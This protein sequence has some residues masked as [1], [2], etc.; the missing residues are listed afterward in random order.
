[1]SAKSRMLEVLTS[2]AA[3]NTFSVAQG[4]RRFGVNNIAARIHE[5]RQ[6]GHPIYSNTR[7]RAD[8]TK[9]V[10]YRYGTLTKAMK[11]SARK[12]RRSA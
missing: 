3:Y 9:V 5:L 10:V 2:D 12:T 11:R 7:S 8:G 1:M 6:D 4:R